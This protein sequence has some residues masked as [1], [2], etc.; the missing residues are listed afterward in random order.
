MFSR[1]GAGEQLHV[2]RQ[3]ADVPAERVAIPA[4]DVGAVEPDHAGLR[5]PD[6][7]DQPD[8]RGLARSARP[9]HAEALA[10]LERECRRL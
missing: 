3:I 4:R 5:L 8:Q 10:R 9:D 1:H 7:E 6:A 2:L